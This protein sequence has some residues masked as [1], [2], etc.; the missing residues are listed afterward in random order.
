MAHVTA[1]THRDMD[2]WGSTSVEQYV[3]TSNHMQ[4]DMIDQASIEE[5]GKVAQLMAELLS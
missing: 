4:L 2:K 5:K 1:A 3:V